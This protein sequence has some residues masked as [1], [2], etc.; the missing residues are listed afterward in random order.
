MRIYDNV[1]IKERRIGRER[2]NDNRRD[3]NMEKG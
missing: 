2:K 1:R 3:R